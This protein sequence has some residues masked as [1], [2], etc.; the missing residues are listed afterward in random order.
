MSDAKNKSQRNQRMNS[1][2]NL[3][4]SRGPRLS[5]LSFDRDKNLF[6]WAN[7]ESVDEI[8]DADGYHVVHANR[9]LNKEDELD[10]I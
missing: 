9:N 7:D 6:Y 5:A 1:A 2:V 4:Q 3:A 8:L 10:E